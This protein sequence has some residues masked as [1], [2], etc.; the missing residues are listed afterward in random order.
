[1]ELVDEAMEA[2]RK[3]LCSR[4]SRAILTWLP[5]SWTAAASPIRYNGRRPSASA[6]VS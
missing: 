4:S 5:P 1:M 2:G 3:V 6:C